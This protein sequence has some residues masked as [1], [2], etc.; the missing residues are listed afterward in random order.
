M[1]IDIIRAWKDAEYR[2]SLSED[3]LARLPQKP[4]GEV[5]LTDEDL[6]N[7]SGANGGSPFTICQLVSVCINSV[8]C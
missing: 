1:N 7:V 8:I 2:E 4:V 3:E 6:L 5:E